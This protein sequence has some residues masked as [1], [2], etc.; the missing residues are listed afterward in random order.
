MHFGFDQQVC[1]LPSG[2]FHKLPGNPFCSCFAPQDTLAAISL[3]LVGPDE[4]VREIP[5]ESHIPG[6]LHYSLGSLANEVVG[7]G[8]YGDFPVQLFDLVLQVDAVLLLDP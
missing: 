3:A 6:S 1:S 5:F 2:L 4:L 7:H 8:P